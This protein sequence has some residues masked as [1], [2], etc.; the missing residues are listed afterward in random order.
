MYSKLM[1]RK[2]LKYLLPL[3]GVALI[4]F[5]FNN[6]GTE[7]DKEAVIFALVR[8]ALTNV[9][10]Q[11]KEM[12]DAL[13]EEIFDAYLEALD[14]NKLFL[15]QGEVDELAKDRFNLDQAFYS[16]STV[17]FDKSYDLITQGIER[18]KQIYTEL[19]AAPFDYTEDESIYSEA[20]ERPFASNVAA[21]EKSWKQHLKWRILNRIYEK[22]HAQREDARNRRR[23]RTQGFCDA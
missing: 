4:I 10:L 2:N 23:C 17:F 7:E 22:D 5:G 19:L 9:H 21:L 8:D 12:D 15:T 14:Y 13:S 18:S 20:K 16:T 3:L 6:Y 1:Q 11:P